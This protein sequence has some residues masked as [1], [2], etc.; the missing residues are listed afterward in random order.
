MEKLN[1]V[2]YWFSTGLLSVMMVMGV[3]MYI[4]QNE[5]VRETFQL[6]GY[7]TYLI[8]PLAAAKI[9]GLIAIWTRKSNLLKEWAYAGFFFD[10]SLAIA[11]HLS[12][13]DGEF[14]PALLALILLLV[15]RFYDGKVFEAD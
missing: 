4:L 7:P 10:F 13:N 5:I 1:K 2:I 14:F 9:L 6:L 11:A 8:Y 3:G 12:I 15:S